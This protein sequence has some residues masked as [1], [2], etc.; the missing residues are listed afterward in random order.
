MRLQ[1]TLI[2]LATL[3]H[4]VAAH[5]DGSNLDYPGVGI[6]LSSSYATLS[7]L[8]ANNNYIDIAKIEGSEA[9]KACMT[10][11]RE[12]ST[13]IAPQYC[14]FSQDFCQ[15]N[16]PFYDIQPRNCL[17]PMLDALITA[18]EAVLDESVPSVAVS[19]YDSIAD[20]RGNDK[21][22][23]SALAA[24]GIPHYGL[25]HV[26][27]H[28]TPALEVL[29]DADCNPYA[30]PGE[31]GFEAREQL[32][33]TV[34]YTG[35]SFTAALYEENC[36]VTETMARASSTRLGHN[37]LQTCFEKQVQQTA[38]STSDT[39]DCPRD[40]KTA[41]E[42]LFRSAQKSITAHAQILDFALLYGELASH[43]DLRNPLRE[44]L[45]EFF[46]NGAEIDLDSRVR[47]FA[48]NA[49]FAGS[50]AVALAGA[51]EMA[52]QRRRREEL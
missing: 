49:D 14:P 5:D 37:A 20:T 15:H 25:R 38:G 42:K 31:P 24:R 7:A 39:Y 29:G 22:T 30:L 34:E 44:V 47:E 23:R 8:V 19:V 18:A 48:P 11:A 3:R 17:A 6:H 40:L 32:F 50:R 27:Q 12:R 46:S 45:V 21:N 33:L 36:G 28:L 10:G 35:H 1:Y 4:G 2:V 13:S 52:R 26:V 51:R 43:A 41:L 16:W 9:F